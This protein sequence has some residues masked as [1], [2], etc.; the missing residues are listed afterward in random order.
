M[1]L[2]IFDLFFPSRV[3][4]SDPSE[5]RS[6]R[7]FQSRIKN[8]QQPLSG[9]S[10]VAVA[11]GAGI[12]KGT[13]GTSRSSGSSSIQLNSQGLPDPFGSHVPPHLK[14]ARERAWGRR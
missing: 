4:G 1:I 2:F 8:Q 9:T 12:A 3:Y 7:E 5:Y 6:S 10:G 11:K 13:I 14:Q